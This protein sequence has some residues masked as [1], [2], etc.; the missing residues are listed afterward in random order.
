MWGRSSS[1]SIR[2]SDA[3]LIPPKTEPLAEPVAAQDPEP[4]V[5]E[6]Q[7]EYD[8]ITSEDWISAPSHADVSFP[9]VKQ[10]DKSI[11]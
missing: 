10:L 3:E 6:M 5:D 11:K 7:R 1:S 9:E 8:E 4:H 2:K